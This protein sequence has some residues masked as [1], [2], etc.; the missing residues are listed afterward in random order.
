MRMISVLI[1]LICQS[2][3]LSLRAAACD[4]AVAKSGWFRAR[5]AGERSL[6]EVGGKRLWS[7]GAALSTVDPGQALEFEVQ[8]SPLTNSG[9]F[10]ENAIE[11]VAQG[12]GV[13]AWTFSFEPRSAA[14]VYANMSY[15]GRPR[16][17]SFR[18]PWRARAWNRLR[19]ESCGGRLR[20][21]VNGV[22][23]SRELLGASPVALKLR[24]M[25]VNAEI[26][27]VTVTEGRP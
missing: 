3:S 14:M 5:E 2:F 20:L 21:I 23:C 7:G 10:I 9:S 8:V 17:D 11:L 24:A 12:R 4:G 27:P 22:P 26:A 13:G 1:L 19:V 16:A 18:A 6:L 25:G 15:G